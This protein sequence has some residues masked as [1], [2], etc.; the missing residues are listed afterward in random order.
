MSRS[1]MVILGGSIT[2]LAVLRQAARSGYSPVLVSEP[3]DVAGFSRFGRKLVGRPDGDCDEATLRALQDIGVATT[4]SLIATSDAWLRFIRR[5]EL[6]LRERFALILHPESDTLDTCVDKIR[7]SVWC[8]DHRVPSPL[9]Y[10]A[11]SE[12]PP[13]ED[14]YPLMLRPTGSRPGQGEVIQ[15]AAE[16][17]SRDELDRYL[18]QTRES[19]AGIIITQSLLQRDLQ[20]YS[21][22]FVR[23]NS[24]MTSLVL[25]KRRPTAVACE[26][27]TLVRL[28][29]EPEVQALGESVARKLD[30]FGIGEVE[31]LRDSRTGECFVIEV[32]ARPWL[33]FGLVSSAGYDWLTY[34]IDHDEY[35]APNERKET[36]AWL[37]FA[38]DLYVCFSRSI[39]DVRHGRVRLFSY[40]ASFAGVRTF[41]TWAFDDRQPFFQTLKRQLGWFS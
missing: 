18:E 7:F 34:L 30:F 26:C 19:E 28:V 39:G 20:Q 38:D 12:L 36:G 1:E 29:D 40:L 37:S 24:S 3:D 22:G 9:C 15:K 32:N 11:V 13:D 6:I 25:E 16:V 27:G 35:Q 41:S 5:N 33:Q 17:R 23:R 2:G 10:S 14:I 4:A 21:V 8:A 31:I